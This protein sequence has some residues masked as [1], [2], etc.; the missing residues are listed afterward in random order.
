[1]SSIANI[2]AKRVDWKPSRMSRAVRIEVAAVGGTTILPPGRDL[3]VVHDAVAL[4]EDLPGLP[5]ELLD[6]L[7]D[8]ELGREVALVD[9]RPDVLL[10]GGYRGERGGLRLGT[11]EEQ[12]ERQ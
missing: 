1:M 12:A 2:M 5:L 11:A 4:D 6:G 9:P 10:G 7:L 3:E 8:V